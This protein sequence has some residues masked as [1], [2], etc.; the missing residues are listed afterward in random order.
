MSRRFKFVIGNRSAKDEDGLMRALLR[1]A[2]DG[3][4]VELH[5]NPEPAGAKAPRQ[6]ADEPREQDIRDRLDSDLEVRNRMLDAAEACGQLRPPERQA[7]ETIAAVQQV[8]SLRQ[9]LNEVGM[10]ILV[11]SVL[12]A[13]WEQ[14]KALWDSI[15]QLL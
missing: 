4:V 9:I 11:E 13:A 3:D 12:H 2:K 5:A 1:Q 10:K 7:A 8:K 14:R 15:R 6:V